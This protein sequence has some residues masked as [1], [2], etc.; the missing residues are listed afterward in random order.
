MLDKFR[1]GEGHEKRAELEA[2]SFSQV[3]FGAAL[4]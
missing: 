1:R 3:N 2:I 4:D